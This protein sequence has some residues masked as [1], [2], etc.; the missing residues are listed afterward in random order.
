[1]DKY[2]IKTT[3]IYKLITIDNVTE[4]FSDDILIELFAIAHVNV[5][6]KRYACAVSY[7]LIKSIVYTIIANQSIDCMI[8]MELAA[9]YMAIKNSREVNKVYCI[10]FG[11]EKKIAS[12]KAL[13]LIAGLATAKQITGPIII[14]GLKGAKEAVEAG[15]V[16]GNLSKTEA[17]TVINIAYE[18]EWLNRQ[19]V[20][21]ISKTKNSD[22]IINE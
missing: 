13:R 6:K 9:R 18:D 2:F 3:L 4:I 22:N 14:D 1:M 12:I 19:D 7:D 10:R 11:L 15:C 21:T 5:V 17:R 8:R 20:L 16:I